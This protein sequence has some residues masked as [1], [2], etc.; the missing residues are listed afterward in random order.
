MATYWVN[1]SET[2]YYQKAVEADSEDE[3]RKLFDNGMMQMLD[4]DIVDGEKVEIE[5]ITLE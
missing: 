2:V 3:A 5:V 4:E 1:A